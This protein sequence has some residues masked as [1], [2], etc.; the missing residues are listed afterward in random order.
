MEFV[1]DRL[2]WIIS[3]T[4]NRAPKPHWSTKL[5]Q[6]FDHTICFCQGWMQSSARKLQFT[7]ANL[8]ELINWNPSYP[9]QNRQ[10]EHS[11]CSQCWSDPCQ[12]DRNIAWNFL[13]VS[14]CP[15]SS[16]F[17]PCPH[18]KSAPSETVEI[19]EWLSKLELYNSYKTRQMQR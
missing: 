4:H 11:S 7:G 9:R 5:I 6:C 3:W 16:R 19:A 14:A 13:W 2:M 1:S 8:R 15:Y 10:D 18:A 12:T 17:C